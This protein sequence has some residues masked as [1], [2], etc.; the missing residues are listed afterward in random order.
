MKIAKTRHVFSNK[1]LQWIITWL[2]YLAF[3]F[4]FIWYHDVRGKPFSLFTTEKCT[5]I[6]SL[7]CLGLALL[8]GPLSRFSSTFNKLLPY[9]RTL[10]VTAAFMTIPHALLVIF[11]LPFKFPKKYSEEYFLSWFVA[12]WFTIVVG[13]LIFFLFMVIAGYSFKNGIQKLGKRKWMILQKFSYLVL[14]MIMLHLL[15]MGKIP[16]NWIKW[17]ETRNYPLP[18]GSFASMCMCFL[19][20]IFKI[21]DLFVHGDSLASQSTE[22]EN[23]A[24]SSNAEKVC[25]TKQNE[26]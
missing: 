18:P 9:R 20:L 12:H 22:Q 14:V 15:S 17:L 8:L 25:L 19:V 2:I 23:A 3:F 13:F 11:Y 1:T 7:Y 26:E 10:G 24:T 6:A 5:A 4:F 16:V 21:V